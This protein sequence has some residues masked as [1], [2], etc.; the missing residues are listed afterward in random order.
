MRVNTRFTLS[1]TNRLTLLTLLVF[2]IGIWSITLYATRRLQQDMVDLLGTQQLSTVSTVAGQLDEA[3]RFRLRAL[4]RI[5]LETTPELLENPARLEEMIARNSV[6]QALFTGG[7]RVHDAQAGIVAQV[8]YDPTPMGNQFADLDYMTIALH[9]GR[10]TTGRAIVDRQLAAPKIAMA[11]PI[12]GNNDQIIG[13]IAGVIDLRNNSF[14]DNVIRSSLG[15][16]GSYLLISPQHGMSVTVSE[17]NRVISSLPPPGV[18]LMQDRFIAGFEGYGLATNNHG[19][20][21][22]TAAKQIRNAGWFLVGSVPTA[23]M[24]APVRAMQ[25]QVMWA[26]ALVSVLAG[27]L[28]ALFVRRTLH[29]QFEPMLAATRTLSSMTD[30]GGSSLVPLAVGKDDEVGKLITGFN[31]LLQTLETARL[32]L[33]E[34]E[35]HYRTLA[36]GGSALI[37]TSGIDRLCNYVNEPWLHFTGR[38][39]EEEIGNGWIENVHPEDVEHCCEIYDAAFDV[40]VHYSMEYR[41][42]HVDGDYHWVRTDA[43]PRFDS[44]GHFLGYIA[45]CYD[46]TN[47]KQ[48]QSQLEHI[49]HYDALTGLPNRLLL[50]DRLRQAMNQAPRRGLLLAVAYIDLDA[51]KAV[52]DTYGHKIGDELLANLAKRMVQILR[53]GDTLGRLGGDEFIAVLVDLP[54]IDASERMFARLLETASQPVLLGDIVLHVTASLGVTFYPQSET[55]DAD[56][57]LRQAD[58]AMYQAKQAGKNRYHLFDAEQDRHVRGRHESLEHIR[59]ALA[60]REF[61]LFYQPKVNMRTGEV[62]GAEALIRWQHPQLGL[63]PPAAFL[64]VIEEHPLAIELGEWV[65]DTALAQI[66]AWQTDE[67]STQLSVNVGALQLQHPNFVSR[68]QALLARYPRVNPG[69]LELEILETSALEDFAGISKVMRACQELGVGFA[70]DDFGTGYSSLTYLKQLPAGLLKVDQSFVR[71]MLGD[72]D[73]VA[74]LVGVLGLAAAFQRKVIAEGVETLAHG[75][76]LLRLGCEWAQGYAVARPMSADDFRRWVGTWEAPSTWKKI[77]PISQDRLPVLFAAVDHRAWIAA[78]VNYLTGMRE[79]PPEQDDHQCRFGRWLDLGGRELL[80]GQSAEPAVDVLHREIHRLAQE[81]VAL[82]QAAQLHEVEA[83]IDALHRLRDQL[84]EQLNSLL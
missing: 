39:L 14:F 1:L 48:Y 50:A 81:L 11:A 43:S 22:L 15:A 60:N 33:R 7:I 46:I 29:R 69:K 73:D 35:L 20:E 79:T 34:H 82:K 25:R 63:L 31:K 30:P 18:N 78:M 27:I 67:L 26:A 52:N 51:F 37:W 3:L 56:Q 23:E 74:I 58:Q 70:L 80:F 54:D 68:L 2:L 62:I 65:I 45:F 32:E 41:L 24:F 17:K 59:Q 8:G 44:T 36:N 13:A 77:K 61:V 84:L 66:E 83:Q 57:L 71:D 5:A 47:I 75:E 4:E 72:P 40:R 76:M 64:P 42:R 10:T 21:E 28:V 38:R 9:E 16:S 49:A 53:D 19:Y 6:L 12:R 55:I